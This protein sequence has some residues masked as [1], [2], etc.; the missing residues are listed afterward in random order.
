MRLEVLQMLAAV[1]NHLQESAARVF[2]FEIFLE[3]EGKLVDALA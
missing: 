2:V 1:C 3:V